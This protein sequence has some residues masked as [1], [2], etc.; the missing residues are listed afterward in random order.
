MGRPRAQ[1]RPQA[2]HWLLL[3][4][5]HPHIS[6]PGSWTDKAETQTYLGAAA[7][8]E[9]HSKKSS[10]SSLSL[11]PY[12]GGERQLRQ[13]VFP[14]ASSPASCLSLDTIPPGHMGPVST[15]AL[16]SREHGQSRGWG[17]GPG[18]QELGPLSRFLSYT[19]GPGQHVDVSAELSC[20]LGHLLWR[21]VVPRVH[22]LQWGPFSTQWWLQQQSHTRGQEQQGEAAA[23]GVH[24]RSNE[25][26]D[27][28][29]TALTPPAWGQGARAKRHSDLSTPPPRR[30][31]GEHEQPLS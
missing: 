28:D 21:G 14:G 9:P 23:C 7:P 13:A 16:L 1:G 8:G 22:W 5:L 11:F 26:G 19:P 12:L 3:S 17:H 18:S 15:E 2:S 27:R 20:V 29:G 31:P 4:S 24:L 10:V 25:Q 6:G 30:C